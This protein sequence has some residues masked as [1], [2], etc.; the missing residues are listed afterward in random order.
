MR[1][2]LF[3]RGRSCKHFIV[4]SSCLFP[5]SY[6]P[7][8]CPPEPWRRWKLQR[9]RMPRRNPASQN[10]GGSVFHLVLRFTVSPLR[11][12]LL[13][14]CSVFP[15]RPAPCASCPPKSYKNEGGC[16][17]RHVL[18]DTS[19]HLSDYAPIHVFFLTYIINL[20]DLKILRFRF[21]YKY[22]FSVSRY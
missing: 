7:Q 21:I 1:V 12:F 11:R 17:L 3:Y 10:E 13:R 22:R 18:L 16:A 20:G 4:P 5:L 14:P 19:N 15:L 8:T 9:S 6:C 2:L